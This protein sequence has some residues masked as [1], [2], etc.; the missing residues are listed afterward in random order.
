[1]SSQRNASSRHEIPSRSCGNAVAL[2]KVAIALEVLG[3]Y[4]DEGLLLFFLQFTI[5]AYL[6]YHLEH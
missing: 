6:M 1:M 3:I 4:I 2:Q 5:S